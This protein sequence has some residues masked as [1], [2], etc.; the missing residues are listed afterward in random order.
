MLP[1]VEG[2]QARRVGSALEALYDRCECD[3]SLKEEDLK[4][5]TKTGDSGETSLFGGGRVKKSDDR[6][7]A[8]G[9]LDEL[10][11]ML[12]LARAEAAREGRLEAAWREGTDALLHSIQNRLFDLGAELATPD[13]HQMGTELIGPDQVVE[14]EKAIDQQELS[15]PPLKEFVLPGG[16][17]LAA[18]LHV[19]RCICRR[20]E[21]MMVALDGQQKLREVTL[22]YVNRLS[23]L[24]FVLARGANH[25]SGLSDVLWAKNKA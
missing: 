4:I 9:A 2:T 12:G 6:L 22:Q 16:S 21:R 25:E 17:S 20:A 14:L 24:L 13:P 10:N 3:S 15:L 19:A 7:A 1:Q 5:Y 8:F 11:A 23:D 18:Q